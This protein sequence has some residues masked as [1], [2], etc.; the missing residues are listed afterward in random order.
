M[1]GNSKMHTNRGIVKVCISMCNMMQS[2]KQYLKT[3]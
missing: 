1:R 2:F 3:M